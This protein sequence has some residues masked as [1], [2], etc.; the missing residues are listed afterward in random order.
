MEGIEWSK[1]DRHSS[2][3]KVPS[4]RNIRMYITMTNSLAIYASQNKIRKKK[5][6]GEKRN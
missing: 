5:G 3:T 1:V 6:D 2:Y 4:I